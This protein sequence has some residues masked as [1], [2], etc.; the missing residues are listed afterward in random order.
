MCSYRG[1]KRKMF[2]ESSNDSVML[3]WTNSDPSIHKNYP[4]NMSQVSTYSRYDYET[5]YNGKT[6]WP[7]IQFLNNKKEVIHIWYYPSEDFDARD[8]DLNDIPKL[9]GKMGMLGSLKKGF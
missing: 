2:I 6:R 9:L 5:M 4:V 7:G 3:K 8:R 1:G